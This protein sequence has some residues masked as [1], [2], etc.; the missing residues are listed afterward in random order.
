MAMKPRRDDRAQGAGEAGEAVRTDRNLTPG[1]PLHA[2]VAR[3]LRERIVH[4]IYAVGAQIPAEDRLGEEFAVSRSTIRQALRQLQLD[5]LIESRKGSGSI[6]LSAA[7]SNAEYLHATSIDDLLAYSRGRQFHFQSIGMEPID[8]ELATRIGVPKGSEWL[9]LRG[10]GETDGHVQ[11]DCWAE[12]YI[13]QDFAAIGRLL[14][15]PV[16]APIFPLIETRFG[17]RVAEVDQE[18]TA[19]VI[20]PAQASALEV[21]P[22]TAAIALHRVYTTSSGQVALITAATYP[23]RRF[24]HSIKLRRL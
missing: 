17:V 20:L 11:P 23:A 18:M 9:T 14:S 22:G 5:R 4:G 16:V 1:E 10:Y 21:E 24:K 15:N 3:T 6:V 8:A 13:H 7:A 12:Y 19:A 2:W